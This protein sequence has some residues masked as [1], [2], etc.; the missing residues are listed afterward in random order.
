MWL[1][2]QLT[3]KQVSTTLSLSIDVY[4]LRSNRD[5]IALDKQSDLLFPSHILEVFHLS[6]T[7]AG[8]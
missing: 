8:M 2:A 1:D 7:C 3:D 5:Q 4:Q 6:C